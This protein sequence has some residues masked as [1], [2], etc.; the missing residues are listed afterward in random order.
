[1]EEKDKEFKKNQQQ[2]ELEA[3]KKESEIQLSR[4]RLEEM[5]QSC[6]AMMFLLDQTRKEQDQKEIQQEQN[7]RV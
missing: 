1:M 4:Q 3:C 5:N 2:L 6:A 7:R